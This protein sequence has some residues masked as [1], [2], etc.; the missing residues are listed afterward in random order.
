MRLIRHLLF[1][2]SA[3]STTAIAEPIV[4]DDELVKLRLKEMARPDRLPVPVESKTPLTGVPLNFNLPVA[5]ASD[6]WLGEK[7][8]IRALSQLN[9]LAKAQNEEEATSL[10]APGFLC[11]EFET[12]GPIHTVH[13]VAV[14]VG[15]SGKVRSISPKILIE[16]IHAL[17][18]LKLKV[19]GVENLTT[20]V[21]VEAN[22]GDGEYSATWLCSWTD[23]SPPK[24]QRL[25]VANFEKI[26]A[27]GSWFQDVT[28]A[29]L[30]K[31]PRF[32]AQV[33][34]GIGSWSQRITRIGDLAMTGHHGIAVGDVNG[35]GLEDIYVC[36]GG[37]LPNQ[38]YLQQADGTAK[39]VASK[40]GVAWLEDSRSALLV[41]LD[42]DGDQDLVVAT[43]AM[44]AFAE[45]N[46]TGKFE[47]RGGF[48]GAPY[49]FSLSAADFDSDG[50]LDIYTCV[51]SADDASVSGKRGF[52]ASSPTPFNDAE[53]GGRNVLLANL[54]DFKFGDVT[55]Q[56][57]M[58]QNNTR[59][60]FAASWEDFDRD[61]DPDLYVANDFG[62]NCLYRNDDGKFVN[63]APEVGAEDM[64][65]GMSVSWGDFN[66]DG[67]ADLFVGN[68]FSSAG[69]RVAFQR[70]FSDGKT[71]MARGNTLFSANDGV[72]QDHSLESGVTNGGWAWSSGFADLNNDGWQ[73]LVVANG[74]LTNTRDDDL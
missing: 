28:K 10:L 24:L 23:E 39:E 42:N 6:S 36:D 44:I 54:S 50:D 9:R 14:R 43:I 25:E 41:D 30:E 48:P 18:E 17:G 4:V 22:R 1:L 19:I 3:L 12:P 49:P 46:G 63:S 15:T 7:F 72:F 21:H 69:Q 5:E 60:S 70:K 37:S 40:W 56:V 66:R 8:T 26:R 27:E 29:A 20:R 59:W 38:L 51:Y 68:M 57:G 67:E 45:N 73:D 47:L 71:R 74:Y 61:G 13:S 31:N 16:E 64:A 11:S 32:E 58:D 62:R 2:F 34:R 55:K 53:N 52:E 35:D 65:A 33:L